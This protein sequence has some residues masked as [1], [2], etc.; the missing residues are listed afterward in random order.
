VRRM[1][2]GALSVTGE[3]RLHAD[4]DGSDVRYFGKRIGAARSAHDVSGD[5]AGLSM[6]SAA[7]LAPHGLNA[8]TL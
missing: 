7:I 5:C 2:E 3:Q 8:L 1:V 6:K 4:W